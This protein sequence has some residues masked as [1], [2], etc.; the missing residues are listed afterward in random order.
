[1]QRET[2]GADNGSPNHAFSVPLRGWLDGDYLLVV[3]VE[4]AVGG[5]TAA[6]SAAFSVQ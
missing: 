2:A 4:D 6:A 5:R 1:M 3:T